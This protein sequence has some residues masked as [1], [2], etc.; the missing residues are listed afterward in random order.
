MAV[1]LQD[2]ADRCKDVV[3]LC[4]HSGNNNMDKVHHL[5]VDHQHLCHRSNNNNMD[6]DHH[7]QGVVLCHRNN[8]TEARHLQDHLH[9]CKG[10]VLCHR[11]NSN[12]GVHQGE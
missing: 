12:S 2:Q 3:V 6:K 7:L 11:S 1:L 5:Q 10:V 8:S 4:H 9:Q